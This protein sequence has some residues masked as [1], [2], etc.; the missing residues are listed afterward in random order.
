[1]QAMSDAEKAQLLS[2]H[3]YYRANVANWGPPPATPLPTL[4]WDDVL[5]GL[6]QDFADSC[7][8]DAPWDFQSRYYTA[9]GQ[10]VKIGTCLTPCH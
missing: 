3:N 9:T 2:D 6:T 8:P 4:V 5:G 7:D 10:S 1:M